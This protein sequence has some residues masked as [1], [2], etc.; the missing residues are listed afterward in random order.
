MKTAGS[1]PII[2]KAKTRLLAASKLA[3][4]L[5]RLLRLTARELR[6]HPE[7]VK[8]KPGE[9][10]TLAFWMWE[11]CMSDL[12]DI[13]ELRYLPADLRRAAQRPERNLAECVEEDHQDR[14]YF[15]RT[16]ARRKARAALAR[17]KKAAQAAR[18]GG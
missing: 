14:L 6:K 4:E 5:V 16:A 7:C 13:Q 17:R 1:D 11:G 9:D 2:A 10:P 12:N 15:A 3:A 18:K 8:E